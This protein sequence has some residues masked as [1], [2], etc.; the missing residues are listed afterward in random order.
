M[1]CSLMAQNFRQGFFINQLNKSPNCSWTGEAVFF[2][3]GGRV[4]SG[5]VGDIWNTMAD[6][7]NF[8]LNVNDVSNLS[9][10][11]PQANGK[12][13]GLLGELQNGHTHVIPQLLMENNRR[14]VVDFTQPFATLGVQMVVKSRATSHFSWLWSLTPF[15][16]AVWQAVLTFLLLISI[17]LY[18]SLWT[19]NKLFPQGKEAKPDF[20]GN[21][22][23][24]YG[25]FCYQGSAS[26][27][28]LTSIKIMM[29]WTS[30]LAYI[31]IQAYGATLVSHI[32]A[33]ISWEPSFNNL[34]GLLHSKYSLAVVSGSDIHSALQKSHGDVYE[35][36]WKNAVKMVNND[37][38]AFHEVC[39]GH[40]A[41][42]VTSEVSAVMNCTVTPVSDLYFSFWSSSGLVKDFPCKHLIDFT[43]LRLR[44]TGILNILM[45]RHPSP[46]WKRKKNHHHAS[47][48]FEGNVQL[49]QIVPILSLY[50]VSIILAFFVLMMETATAMHT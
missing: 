49:L 15:S 8:S 44:E 28:N 25:F 29:L 46:F 9:L 31:L 19:V 11:V 23:C 17:T 39:S 37:Q 30:L 26:R 40:A 13:T 14:S 22:M 50:T 1:L 27:S 10:G 21:F 38:Q 48:N 18:L 6:V 36:V 24:I 5:Y 4:I 41:C 2:Q 32:T 7:L 16:A 3:S 42:F 12:W 43:I 47:D 35:A 34:E 20:F 33:L 45:T